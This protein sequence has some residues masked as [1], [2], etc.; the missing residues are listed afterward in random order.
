MSF[1][2]STQTPK[3]RHISKKLDIKS[4]SL[5]V[6]TKGEG[7]YVELFFDM[8]LSLGVENMKDIQNKSL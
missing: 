3:G 4:S 7:F 2:F 5:V 8:C 6:T 1:T